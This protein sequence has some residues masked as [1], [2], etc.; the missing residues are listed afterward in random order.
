MKASFLKRRQGFTLIE[1]LVVIAII[2]I[3]IA[4][5]L[6]A[7]QQAREA[8]RRS[9]CKNNLKQIG[10]ALHNYH[11]AS[12]TFPA[13][14]IRTVANSWLSSQIGWQARIL[15]YV[16]QA[17]L[18]NMVDWSIQPG[19]TG[20]AN[21]TVMKTELPVYRC[22]SDPGDRGSTGQSGYGPTNYVVCSAQYGDFAAGGTAF[23]DNGKSIMFLNS[24]TRMRDI[25]DGTSNTMIASECKVGYE[26]A[27]AN[28]TS[29]TVC[30]GTA[31][32]KLRGYT[33]FWGQAMHMWSYS[34]LIGPNSQLLEC[35]SGTGGP[36]LMG[37]RSTHVGGVH[38]LFADGRIQFISEN[39]NLG[40]WQNLGHKSDGN[41]IGE[42]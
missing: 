33:W 27:S 14:H 36:A 16:D 1:L 9:T 34:T 5:L 30:T 41:I 42:Y 24:A 15:P 22:P 26:Y 17:N 19:N 10:L 25:T 4:L 40:T 18:Y 12:L 28:A 7:V 11:D 3:L 6:P 29:G 23:A 35:S 39:I 31:N 37:A 13:S 2:A 32:Q 21:T 20:T 8:A 38:V